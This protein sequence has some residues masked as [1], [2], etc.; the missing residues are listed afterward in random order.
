M[1]LPLPKG[2]D[3]DSTLC[4]TTLM[5]DEIGWEAALHGCW[6]IGWAEA[7]QRHYESFD[8]KN[9]GKRWPSALIQKLWDVSWKMWEH[10]NAVLT[11]TENGLLLKKLNEEIETEYALG[12]ERFPSDMRYYIQRPLPDMLEAEE[13]EKRAWLLR[14]Q[15]A[16]D[17]PRTQEER[18]EDQLRQQ[19]R[20]FANWIGSTT[21]ER[22]FR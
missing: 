20:W 1:G 12:F 11:D 2:R 3:P 6:A 19:Q 10:R 18:E 7:Q 17:L 9:T 16:R 5:Q 14:T 21:T 8:R 22:H 4:P 13:M 15:T